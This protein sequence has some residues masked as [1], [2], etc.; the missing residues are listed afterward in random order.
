MTIILYDSTILNDMDYQHRDKELGLPTAQFYPGKHHRLQLPSQAASVVGTIGLAISRADTWFKQ[1]RRW[2]LVS[3]CL[4]WDGRPGVKIV[5]FF[6]PVADWIIRE[7]LNWGN[8]YRI[9][10]CF[11]LDKTCRCVLVTLL[12]DITYLLYLLMVIHLQCL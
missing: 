5:P 7:K 11:H 9:H 12:H 6:T 1:D 4:S 8:H 3:C 10:T 2:M